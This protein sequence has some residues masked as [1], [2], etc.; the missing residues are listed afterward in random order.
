MSNERPVRGLLGLTVS[1][2]S[3]QVL[4]GSDFSIFV[5]VHNPF[6]VPVV[7]YDVETHIPVELLDV[8]LA[9]V[10]AAEARMAD[11][12]ADAH[13]GA[14]FPFLRA[15]I[16]SRRK[17]AVFMEGQTGVAVA[18][19]TEFAPEEIAQA[20]VQ[21]SITVG[22]ARGDTTIAGVLFNF[23]ENPSPEELE[24][25]EE[26]DRLY[27]RFIKYKR[28]VT[29]IQLQPGDSVV[30]QFRLRTRSWLFFTPLAHTFQIQT[31]YSVDGVD[32][33]VTT[34]YEIS[35]RANMT[36]AAIGSVVGSLIGVTVRSLSSSSI[37]GTGLPSLASLFVAML[38]SIAIV[39]AFAR[40]ATAQSLVS[41]EDFWGGI[42]IGVS[43]GYF[44]FAT[45]SQVFGSNG[46]SLP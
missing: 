33:M 36:A 14:R 31:R 1:G 7:L 41:V 26:L 24:S 44:G 25:P 12:T 35:I 11:E 22:E 27:D 10:K 28:G 13:G 34:P 19:G 5:I 23:P 9:R 38:A 37:D 4:A 46:P 2:S 6:E 21:T 42:V 43:V 29:P 17:R 32:H 16:R 3:S 18:T 8:N 15:I 20:G 45:F 40:R 30:R 39:A